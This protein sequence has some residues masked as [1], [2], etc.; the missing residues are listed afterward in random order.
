MALRLIKQHPES[1]ETESSPQTQEYGTL[2][3]AASGRGVAYFD[4]AAYVAG[5]AKDIDPYVRNRFNQA[6]SDALP[7]NRAIPDTRN[8]MWVLIFVLYRTTAVT[9]AI[10]LDVRNR[11]NPYKSR[12][13]WLAREA[14]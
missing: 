12:Q 4:E 13:I 9:L 3:T 7:S 14:A 10:N 1:E 6:A 2:G 11:S 5:G 8:A